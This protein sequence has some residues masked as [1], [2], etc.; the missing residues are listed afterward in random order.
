MTD[1]ERAIRELD[2]VRYSRGRYAYES[3]DEGASRVY[4]ADA[5]AMRDLGRR[6]RCG[7]P[8]AYSLW[9]AE[10]RSLSLIT[11]PHCGGILATALARPSPS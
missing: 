9:C 2:A 1:L 3:T 5:D 10:T 8:D 7:Q 11:C 4:V 6:L